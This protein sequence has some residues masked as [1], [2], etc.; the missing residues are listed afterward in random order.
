MIRGLF[1]VG[2]AAGLALATLPV[3]V[4]ARG[5]GG[6]T[7]HAVGPIFF[8]GSSV[9]HHH[10]AFDYGPYGGIVATY[11]PGVEPFGDVS[12][13]QALSPVMP[14]SFVLSCHHSQEIKTVLSEE[15]GTRQITITRC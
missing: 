6:H 7:A 9:H 11:A 4:A 14:T 2:I 3:G 10:R 8:R 13:L 12:T 15:G 1:A 5:F